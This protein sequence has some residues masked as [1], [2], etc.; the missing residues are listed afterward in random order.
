MGIIF[1]SKQQDA[2]VQPVK[3]EEV[4]AENVEEQVA[5]TETPAVEDDGEKTDDV[6]L[7]S[8]PKM[9]HRGRKRK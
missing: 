6:E 2:E 8:K 5:V 9:P 3:E 1:G 4:V 7:Q